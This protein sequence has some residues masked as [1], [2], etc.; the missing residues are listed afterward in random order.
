LTNKEKDSQAISIDSPANRLAAIIEDESE[1]AVE[2]I[3][4]ASP[5]PLSD[6]EIGKILKKN[7]R[8]ISGIIDNLNAKYAQWGRTFRIEKFGSKYRYYTLP[9]YD[10]FIN[11]LAEIP[12]P[13]KLSRASLEVLSIIAYRQPVV[14]ADI[15]KIRGINSDG[16]TRTLIERSLIEIAGR[17]DGPG[18][19]ILYKTTREFLEFFGIS[20]LSALPKHDDS[21]NAGDIAGSLIISR[22][23][24]DQNSPPIPRMRLNKFLAKS[25]IASRRAADLLIQQ[26][27]IAV[28]GALVTQ[29]GV[30]INEESDK[31][32]FNN[33]PVT[34]SYDYIYLLVHKPSGY[35]ITCKDNHG[36]PII[37]DLVS[38]YKKIVKPVG[39]LDY[40]SSGL[41]ILTNDGEFAFRL[42]HPRYEI[43]KKYLVKCEGSISDEGIKKLESGIKLHDGLTSPA[44]IE[45][46]SRNNNYSRFYITIHEGRKRQI[47]RMCG[48]IGLK[49][50]ALKRISIGNLEL[51]NLKSGRYR[52]L[53]EKEIAGLKESVRL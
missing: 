32:T 48:A 30:I 3:L 11:R 33:K 20:D 41:I 37:L 34:I 39:R 44:S 22:P 9:D 21:G 31:V 5:E 53:T 25:G 26:G 40:D 38:K 13:V 42:S 4:F 17:S 8:H 12:R 16:V 51:G 10:K 36:R 28:N 1:T 35:I 47:R 6:R 14:K 43:N 23:A 19:P 49:V 18:R 50:V 24:E 29:L 2:A 52:L 15:E 46:V 7:K 27:M 45:L